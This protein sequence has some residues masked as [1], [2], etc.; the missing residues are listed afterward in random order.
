[1][2]PTNQPAAGPEYRRRRGQTADVE[3]EGIENRNAVAR[4]G[5]RPQHPEIPE[6]DLQQQRDVAQHLDVDHR[7]LGYHPVVGQARD[8][9]DEAEDGSEEDS[10]RRNQNR[11][12]QSD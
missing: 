1:M 10:D 4:I 3:E 11:V 8:A 12:Q 6:K 2:V 7:Q 9:E 5:Q